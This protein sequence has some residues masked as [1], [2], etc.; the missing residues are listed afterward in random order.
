MVARTENLSR[1]QLQADVAYLADRAHDSDAFKIDKHRDHGISS[2]SIVALIYGQTG[3]QRMPADWSDYGA[4]VRA[5]RKMPWHRRQ[6]AFKALW[7]A[8]AAVPY[9]AS[10]RRT[11]WHQRRV[12]VMA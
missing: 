9:I 3:Y 12:E 10:V 1:E 7:R 6:H 11:R 8:R 4:C 2:N 5:V